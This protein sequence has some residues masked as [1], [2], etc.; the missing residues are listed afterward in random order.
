M[1]TVCRTAAKQYTV[2][3]ACEANKEPKAGSAV[4]IQVMTQVL[5]TITRATYRGFILKQL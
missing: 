3:T 5:Q 1:H 4:L 2:S